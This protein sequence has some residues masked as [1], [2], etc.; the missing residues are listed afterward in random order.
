VILFKLKFNTS[1]HS[2]LI[3]NQLSTKLSIFISYLLNYTKHSIIGMN[4]M[5]HSIRQ[6]QNHHPKV[7]ER[8]YIDPMATVIGKVTLGNEVSVWPMAVIRG[9]VNYINIGDKCSIQDAAILHVTHDGP[10]TPGGRPLIIGE[11]NT[12]GHQAVLHACTIEDYCLIGMGA[13]LL[14]GAHIEKQVIIGAGSLV[15][16]GKR[17][18]TGYLYLG[19]PVR[20]VRKL[21]TQEMEQLIYSAEHYVR[22]KD[23]YLLNASPA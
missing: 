12:I 4:H 17:L 8:V 6:F 7:G 18:E 16:P 22:L 15:P 9:D 14:D 11:G 2:R 10:Y 5:N 1:F 21:T 13:I 20:A 23:K 3:V 19:N